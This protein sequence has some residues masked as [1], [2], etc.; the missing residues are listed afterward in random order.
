MDFPRAWEIVKETPVEQHNPEC[1]YAQTN[2]ALL[3]DC[4]VLT[5]HPEYIADYGTPPNEIEAIRE[6]IACWSS[7][8]CKGVWE[9]RVI[10]LL[11]ALDEANETIRG[12]NAELLKYAMDVAGKDAIDLVEENAQLKARVEELE[13]RPEVFTWTCDRCGA[14]HLNI[15]TMYCPCE[16]ELLEDE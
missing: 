15:K 1:S 3:C 8:K 4:E 9:K 2:G 14:Q 11:R 7:D 12:Q 13:K 10:T 16:F 5:Q 6:E